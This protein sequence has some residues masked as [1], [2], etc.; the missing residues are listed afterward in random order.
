MNTREIMLKVVS[1]IGV[2]QKIR[3]KRFYDL[4][5]FMKW[6]IVNIPQ[7]V[8][9]NIGTI[10]NVD[11]KNSVAMRLSLEEYNWFRS[12]Y[13]SNPTILIKD[14]KL[15][16]KEVLDR[17]LNIN[18]QQNFIEKKEELESVIAEI[19]KIYQK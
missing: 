18:M 8:R 15:I 6:C 19:D 7:D 17:L 2:N 13:C 4:L 9:K 16:E 12:K 5:D 11:E 3:D 1:F 14:I 10:N